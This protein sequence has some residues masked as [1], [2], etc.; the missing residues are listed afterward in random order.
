MKRTAL[1]ICVFGLM[2]V[3]SSIVCAENTLIISVDSYPEPTLITEV[4][5]LE[6]NAFGDS[7]FF[8]DQ[9]E[10][11]TSFKIELIDSS[12]NIILTIPV[13]GYSSHLMFDD[14]ISSIRLVSGETLTDKLDITFC[15]GDGVCEPCDEIACETSENVLTCAD[16]KSGQN[17]LFCDVIEDGMCDPDCNSDPAD[18]DCVSEYLQYEGIGEYVESMA[19]MQNQPSLTILANGDNAAA[20]QAE[21]SPGQYCTEMAGGKICAPE[22]RCSGRILEYIQGMRCCLGTCSLPDEDIT[23]TVSDELVGLPAIE[24]IS[25]DYDEGIENI[26]DGEFPYETIVELGERPT[27]VQK[28]E[29]FGRSAENQLNKI[30]ALHVAAILLVVFLLLSGATVIFRRSAEKQISTPSLPVQLN[31]QSEIEKLVSAGHTYQQ[32][33]QELMQRGLAKSTVD[34]EINLHYQRRIAAGKESGKGGRNT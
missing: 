31:L 20:A 24:T 32:I 12:G 15:D 5:V 11:D 7:R 17:D 33:E 19:L 21:D 1:L 18:P 34:I 30:N 4:F 29:Q 2:A 25:E 23:D 10:E 22:E 6:Q 14:R 28:V 16:C 26:P 3:F 13:E 8:H 27:V 9:I